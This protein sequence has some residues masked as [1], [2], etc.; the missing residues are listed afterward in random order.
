MKEIGQLELLLQH[1][2]L[3]SLRLELPN[4]TASRDCRERSRIVA[5]LKGWIL[6]STDQVLPVYM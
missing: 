5:Y 2:E 4:Y 1:V 6:V 3:W